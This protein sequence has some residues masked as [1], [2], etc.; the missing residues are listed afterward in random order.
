VSKGIITPEKAQEY[1]VDMTTIKAGDIVSDLNASGV[2]TAGSGIR[3]EIDESA[4]KQDEYECECIEC[5]WTTTTTEHCRDITCDECGGE[6]RRAERPGTGDGKGTKPGWDETDETIRYRVRDPG[7][8]RD[9]TMKTVALKEDKPHVNSVMGKLKANDGEDDDPMVVQNL[10]FPKEDDWTV[11]EAKKWLSEHE[12]VVKTY[13]EL[14]LTKYIATEDGFI[15]VPADEIPEEKSG[16]VLSAKNAGLVKECITDMTKAT[17]SLTKLLEAAEPQE[18]EPDKEKEPGPVTSR[19]VTTDEVTAMKNSMS[20]R[21]KSK[22]DIEEEKRRLK[23]KMEESRKRG[24]V[25][26]A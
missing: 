7:D 16:R 22:V 8:F 23:Q 6:M 17:E 11:D 2:S 18:V 4:V 21:F 19:T 9:D 3:I 12:D 20:N 25:L 24:K 1:G 15:M 5:G 13:F 14:L 26:V 10:M